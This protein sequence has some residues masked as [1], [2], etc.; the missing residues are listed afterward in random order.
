MFEENDDVKS[1]AMLVV[2]LLVCL[3][4]GSLALFSGASIAF[5]LFGM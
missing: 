5:K 4:L 2:F 1:I 3:F